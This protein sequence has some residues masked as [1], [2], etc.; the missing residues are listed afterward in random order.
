MSRRFDLVLLLGSAGI[1]PAV[2]LSMWAGAD[3][4]ALDILVTLLVG[5]PHLFATFTSVNVGPSFRRRHPWAIPSSLLIP[6]VVA[7]LAI[8]RHQTLMSFFIIAA[9]VHVLQQALYL[10]DRYRKKA[11]AREVRFARLVDAGLVF[12]SIYPVAIYKLRAGEF[13]VGG[14]QVVVP[15]FFMHA[16]FMYLE[17]IVFLGFL[18]A[19]VVKTYG[20]LRRGVLNV[21]KTLL[22]ATTAT[23]ALLV[24]ALAG[25]DHMGLAFQSFNA[26]HSIQYLG[27]LWLTRSLV[28]SG[29]SCQAAHP[30][31]FRP[32]ARA[33]ELLSGAR[34][35][36]WFYGANV[37]VTAL[38]FVVVRAVAQWNPLRMADA[39]YYHMFVLSPLLV[40]YYL[41]AIVFATRG[42]EAV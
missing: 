21:P 19:F 1:V 28:A 15:R 31:G 26:W 3:A 27:I 35:P 36:V 20:E 8:H 7:L 11:G 23:V 13:F 38:L 18:V 4:D 39:Q 10:A 25:G 14:V 33:H 2:L 5:G 40:H 24:P 42:R 29:A 9:S 34:G 22:I 12:S 17:W 16:A 6:P 41:D 32:F 37:G 30:G